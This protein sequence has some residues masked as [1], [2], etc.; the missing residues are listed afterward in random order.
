[1]AAVSETAADVVKA[2]AEPI[3]ATIEEEIRDVRRAALAGR[4]AVEDAAAE[5]TV[6]VQ[7]HPLASL[8]IA[9]GV[10][11]LV[12]CAIGFAVGRLGRMHSSR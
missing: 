4:H 12:G 2:Y 11:T 5:A 1:M 6:Q 10:G 9:A 3:R 8:G 7:R